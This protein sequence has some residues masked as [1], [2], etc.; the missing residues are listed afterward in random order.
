MAGY[1]AVVERLANDPDAAVRAA[2]AESLSSADVGAV[3]PLVRR[4]ATPTRASSLAA[5]ESLEMLADASIL[6]E[7]APALDH[8]DPAV[9]ERAQEAAEFIE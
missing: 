2:A 9:R 5:L 1:E 3:R 6:P 4:S 7:L 8:P